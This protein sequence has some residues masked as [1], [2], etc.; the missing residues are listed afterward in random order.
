M[1]VDTDVA[2]RE[3]ERLFEKTGVLNIEVDGRA[4]SDGLMVLARKHRGHRHWLPLLQILATH[5]S[6]DDALLLFMLQSTDD[7]GVLNAIATSGRA[8]ALVLGKLAGSRHRSVREHAKLAALRLEL[9][10]ATE[11]RFRELLK[12]HR[13]EDE[14]EI[15]V[16]A[17]LAVHP[18]TPR[19]VLEELAKDEAD[20]IQEAVSARLE[21]G[22][23]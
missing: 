3:L 10:T 18:R 15:A 7:P 21:P 2:P 6:A 11:T 22:A 13:G 17:L 5:P 1:I 16:R 9:G 14:Q 12:E 19:D 23:T 8:S 4:P 20:F